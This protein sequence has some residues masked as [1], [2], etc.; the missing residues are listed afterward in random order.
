MDPQKIKNK[1]IKGAN[2]SGITVDGNFDGVVITNV[3]FSKAKGNIVI[4]PQS[5]PNKELIGINFANA[6]LCSSINKDNKEIAEPSFEGCIIYKCKFKDLKKPI[7]INLD[8]L[9]SYIYPKLSLCDLT[10]VVVEGNTKSNYEAIHCVREDGTVLFGDDADDLSGSYY[11]DNE[12]NFVQVHLY[13]SMMW[14]NKNICWKYIPRESERNLKLNVEFKNT[15][16]Q[17]KPKR[18]SLFK[19][20]TFSTK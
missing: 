4:N 10:N 8:I 1:S 13:K 15:E 9:N 6:I 17:E 20:I 3:D 11:Y 14:D 2:L 12:G 19:K 16:L 18:L 5:I 7:T